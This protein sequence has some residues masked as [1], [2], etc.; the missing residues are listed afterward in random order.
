LEELISLTN[1][2]FKHEERL[3]LKYDYPEFEDHKEDHKELIDSSR[4]LQKKFVS[5]GKILTNEDIEYLE[6]W[7]TR[8]ILTTDMRL[9]QYLSS[10]M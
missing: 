5:Q 7:L 6:L 10:V 9:G 3:M 8:H 4:E 1:W 2:H